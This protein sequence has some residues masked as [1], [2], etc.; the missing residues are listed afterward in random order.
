MS[1]GIGRPVLVH[2]ASPRELPVCPA[3]CWALGLRAEQASGFL[4]GTTFKLSWA[5]V[6]VWMRSRPQ[7]EDFS[8]Q[9]E[10]IGQRLGRDG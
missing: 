2:S 8:R 7:G 1:R 10:Q 5:D 3:A 9:R 6:M 4:E